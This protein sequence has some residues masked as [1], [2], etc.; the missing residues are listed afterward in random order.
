MLCSLIVGLSVSVGTSISPIGVFAPGAWSQ[1]GGN[2]QHTA[3][4]LFKTQPMQTILWSKPV[5]AFPQYSGNDLL[6]HYG[7]PLITHK[8]TVIVPLNTHGGVNGGPDAF[9]FKA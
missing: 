5:D 9:A 1:Y 7:T 6:I 8:G 2:A 4:S 3:I